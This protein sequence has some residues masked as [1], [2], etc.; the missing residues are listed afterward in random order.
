MKF[1][2]GLALGLA[3]ALGAPASATD[4]PTPPQ[5]P[6]GETPAFPELEL[7]ECNGITQTDTFTVTNKQ[8]A[9][10]LVTKR[11]Q[12]CGGGYTLVSRYKSPWV[13]AAQ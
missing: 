8:G 5:G 9:T 11:T 13:P 4:S 2:L 12:N 7:G 3:I 10:R 1:F 6:V